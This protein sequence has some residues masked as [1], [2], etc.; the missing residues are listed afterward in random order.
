MFETILLGVFVV[1]YHE[2]GHWLAY[3]L[4]GLKPS[5]EFKGFNFLIGANVI[6]NLKGYQAVFVSFMGILAGFFPLFMGMNYG[7]PEFGIGLLALLY[8][9]GLFFDFQVIARGLECWGS[10]YRG[11]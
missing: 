2:T 5:L 6:E 8:M 10:K 7:F 4:L 9:V 11:D 3:R 1:L